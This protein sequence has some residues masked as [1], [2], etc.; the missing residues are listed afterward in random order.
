MDSLIAGALELLVRQTG[1]L[2]VWAVSFGRCRSV[3]LLSDE[4]RI[5]GPAGALSYVHQGK[6]V[7][8]GT[9]LLFVGALFYILLVLCLLLYAATA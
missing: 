5:H 3:S 2:V 6:R 8:T 9:G 4:D 7:V 1:R